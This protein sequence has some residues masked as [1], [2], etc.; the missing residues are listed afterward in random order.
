MEIQ[1]LGHAC[2][3]IRHK[4]Y[5]IVTVSELYRI[6]GKELKPHQVYMAPW[7]DE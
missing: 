6:Y 4:G 2:F 3:A 7:Y 1:W 5:T